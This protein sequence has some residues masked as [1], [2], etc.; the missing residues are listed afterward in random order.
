MTQPATR[1]QPLDTL[2]ELVN[3]TLDEPVDGAALAE[4]AN[5][6]RFYFQRLFRQRTGETPGDCRRRLLLERAAYQLRHTDQ[7]VTTIA[8]EAN[9]DSLEGFSRAFRRAHGVAPSRYRQAAPLSW[10]LAAPNDIHYDPLVGAAIRLTRAPTQGGPMDLT[11]RLLE[12]DLWLMQ[13]MLDKAAAL[14]DEQLDAPLAHMEQLLF[15]ETAEKSL[16]ELLERLIFTKEVWVAAVQGRPLAEQA[17]ATPAGLRQRMDAVYGE[18][19]A[20]ARRVRDEH[21]WDDEFVDLLCDPPE[22]FT[23]G[24]MIS[25]VITFSD[26][27]RL[28]ALHTMKR[29]GVSGLPD[30]CPMELDFAKREE[31]AR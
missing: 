28:A 31:Q 24:G 17:N 29:L 12:H 21:L 5:Y 8:F 25:H 11:D 23:Y 10:F 4:A 18:F 22:T 16:R 14:T 30:G 9:F 20:L 13:R 2:T 19:L 15:F 26:Y 6:S 27:R 3:H 1:N 7:M